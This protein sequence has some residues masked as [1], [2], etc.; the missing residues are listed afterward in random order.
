MWSYALEFHCNNNYSN[1]LN[2]LTLNSRLIMWSASW[3]FR[4][5]FRMSLVH[6]LSHSHTHRFRTFFSFLRPPTSSPWPLPSVNG[7]SS[8]LPE[9]TPII[10]RDLSQVL[11]TSPDL[12]YILSILFVYFIY[13]CLFLINKLH[14]S[15][16]FR[17]L[18]HCTIS[19]VCNII[20]TQ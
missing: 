2:D 13:F 12:A 7:I 16:D 20:A 19:N 8:Y 3:Y 18:V 5:L 11:T 1:I 4:R 14:E 10:R 17:Y 9:R 6:L 15:K